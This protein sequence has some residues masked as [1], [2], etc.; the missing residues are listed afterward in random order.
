[1]FGFES[2]FLV[3]KVTSDTSK[4]HKVI[5]ELDL[6][7]LDFVHDLIKNPPVSDKYGTLRR[8][9]LARYTDSE[10]KR[11]RKLLQGKKLVDG[12]RPSDLLREMKQLAGSVVSAKALKTLWLDALP[13]TLRCILITAPDVDP[14]NPLKSLEEKAEAADRYA[15]ASFLSSSVN[16]MATSAQVDAI[17]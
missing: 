12:Q 3:H 10:E 15:E 14:E 1:M 7:T 9:I 11:I 13:N 16:A 2:Q 8:A 17:T 4:F 6:D 5:V